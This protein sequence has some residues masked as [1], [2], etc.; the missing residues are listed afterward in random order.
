MVDLLEPLML[1]G[2]VL[3]LRALPIPPAIR[4]GRSRMEFLRMI[5]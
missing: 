4:Q 2:R 5:F 1:I 3:D